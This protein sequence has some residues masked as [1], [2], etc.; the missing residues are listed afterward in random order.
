M[1][2]L[3]EEVQPD[4]PHPATLQSEKR[5]RRNRRRAGKGRSND[6]SAHIRTGCIAGGMSTDS[7]GSCWS[8]IYFE[9]A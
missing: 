8:S 1:A 4:R 3:S 7:R 9:A 6:R 5:R 2:Q